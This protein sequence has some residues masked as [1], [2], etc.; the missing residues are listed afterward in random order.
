MGY[1]QAQS[2]ARVVW[3]T[4]Q[5]D[6]MRV[7]SIKLCHTRASACQAFG[8]LSLLRKEMSHQDPTESLGVTSDVQ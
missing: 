1:T 5:G 2:M 4:K 8:G 3:M 6:G 7:Q